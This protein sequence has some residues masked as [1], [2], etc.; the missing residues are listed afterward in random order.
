[1]LRAETF[2]IWIKEYLGCETDLSPFLKFFGSLVEKRRQEEIQADYQASQGAPRTPLPLLWQ[3]ASWYTPINFELFRKEYEQCMGCMVYGCDEFGSLSKY[4]ITVK[5]KTKEQLVQFDSS[6]GTAACT[7]KFF[8]TAGILCCHILKV[9][10][11]RNV[12]EIPPQYFLKRWSKDAKLGT[13]DVRFNFHSD[14]GSSVS[15]RYAA[16]YCLFYKIA[17]KAATN[18][19]TF[20]LVASQ[21]DQLIEGI[22]RTLQS[23]LAD[24]SSVVHSIRAQL[25]HMGQNDYPLGNSSE[26]QN[27]IGKKSEV[28]RRGNGLGTNKRQK[29]RKGVFTVSL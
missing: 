2:G 5:G 12:K 9:Y 28:A 10:E 11:L 13:I 20:A 6:D 7:C 1:M 3:A 15:E 29:R 24:K 23:A 26:A 22:E 8:E 16:L 18:A 21:S 25:T 27:S 19:D 17:A 14:A 4:M